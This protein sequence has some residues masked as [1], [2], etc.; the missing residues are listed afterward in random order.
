MKEIVLIPDVHFAVWL[1]RRGFRKGG[2]F[3]E[4]CVWIGVFVGVAPGLQYFVDYFTARCLLSWWW[5]G[6]WWEEEAGFWLPQGTLHLH[7]VSPGC[8]E[9]GL[10]GPQI[11]ECSPGSPDLLDSPPLPTNTEQMNNSLFKG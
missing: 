10:G 3:S 6:R 2:E 9:G 8:L 11:E 7:W 5:S 4:E 1:G